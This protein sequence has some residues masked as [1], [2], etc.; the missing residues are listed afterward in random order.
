SHTSGYQD[1]YP[2]DYVAPFMER[3]TTSQAILDLWA[4]KA[5]DFDPGTR[6]Q[7]SNTNFSAMGLIIEKLSGQSLFQF[8]RA[9]VFEP[10]KMQSP[11][12]ADTEKWNDSYPTGYH[13]FAMGPARPA[14][15]EAGGWL[16]AAGELAMTAGDLALWDISLIDGTILKP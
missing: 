1:Y 5:L 14:P 16:N 2:L 10:L 11:V 9:R 8:L 3:P 7:Y 6:W 15:P 4:K 12:D 13:R